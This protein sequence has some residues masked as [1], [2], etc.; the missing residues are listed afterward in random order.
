MK[1]KIIRVLLSVLIAFGLWV[2]VVTIVS[3]ESEATFHNI[4]VELIN[5][6]VLWNH[7]LMVTSAEKYTVTVQLRGNRTDLNSLKNSEITAV[8]DLSKINSAGEQAL[9]VQVSVNGSFEIVSQS[10]TAVT[11]Q[12]AEWSTK[13]VPVVINYSG[14]LGLDYI[15]Y[16]DQIT[17]DHET[18]TLTGPKKAVDQITQAVV[19][20]DLDGRVN[21]ITHE[22]YSYTLCNENGEAVDGTGIQP[23]VETVTLNLKIQRVKEIQLAVNVIY[24]G[25]AT[26]E[27]TTIVLDQQTIKV[28]ASEV[29]LDALG[30]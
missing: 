27:N 10:L 4:S 7:G 24:G 18:V 16:K 25:G 12:V 20:V 21:S 13:E 26:E 5:D 17:L 28:S 2:Y 9:N 6:E 30:D 23:D 22:S 19:N 8:A 11:V 15:A 29:V 14:S 1:E 3:P